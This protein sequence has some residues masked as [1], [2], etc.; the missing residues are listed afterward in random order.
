M[1][2]LYIHQYFKTP[3]EPGGTRSYWFSRELIHNGFE[4]TVITSRTHQ[5]R[6][7]EK[8]TVDGIHVIYIRNAYSNDMTIIRRM[9]SFI[10]FMILSTWV[11]LCQK[12]IN[13]VYATSTPLTIGIPA[14]FLKW[15]KRKPFIFEVRDLWPEVPIQMGGLRNPLFKYMALALE[16]II[17]QNARHIVTLSPGMKDGVLKRGIDEKKVSMI[18]NMSKIDKFWRREKNNQIAEIFNID[19]NNF[20]LIHFGTMGRANGLEYI[21]NAA[22]L[23]QKKGIFDVSFIFMGKGAIKEKL[24]KMKKEMKLSNI[25]FI[26]AQPMEIV[27]DVVNLCDVSIVPFVNLPILQTNS[28]N[29]LFDSL[30]AGIPVVVNSAGWTKDLVEEN[31]CG[32][33]VDPGKPEELVEK[34][35]TWKIHPALLVEMG[36]AARKLAEREYD[37]SILSKK[38]ISIIKANL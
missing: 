32:V 4:V 6:L 8:E 17:Y 7:F 26:E 14:L 15:V 34:I 35:L 28:P 18:P 12:R 30:S 5:K 1:R 23:I 9:I 16:K 3:S 33:Y 13:L 2:I 38:F 11:S 19:L 37:K 20:N 10:K 22:N 24:I 36:S 31:Q 29:K 27:S 21:V 25:I